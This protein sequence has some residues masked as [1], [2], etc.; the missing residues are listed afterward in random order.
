MRQRPSVSAG[1]PVSTSV[2]DTGLHTSFGPSP[3]IAY[4]A[5]VDHRQQ[6][7]MAVCNSITS[8]LLHLAP[9]EQVSQVRQSLM[10]N[11]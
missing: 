8:V 4:F 3:F 7:S 6:L 10:S 1:L 5:V 9:P 2:I 11:V